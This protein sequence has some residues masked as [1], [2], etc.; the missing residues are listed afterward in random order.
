M[1]RFQSLTKRY[2]AFAAVEDLTFEVAR[3]ESVALWGPNGAGKTTAIKCLL[4]LLR[5]S[6]S[7]TVDGIE[8]RRDGRRARSRMGYVPQELAFYPEL[9]VR[10]T[11]RYYARLRRVDLSG[12]L[13]STLE[14]VGL[15]EHGHKHVSALS[16]GMKQRLALGLALL[17]SPPV[18]VLDEPTANLDA[19]ARRQFLG[20]LARVRR[21][22]Q[23]VIFT[24][25]RRE[26]V[27]A[28]AAWVLVM[29]RGRERL[30]CPATELADAVGLRS[31]LHLR[32][33][34]A[35]TGPALALLRA[36]GYD[37]RRNGS[38]V[39]LEVSPSRK[40][41]PI[42]SLTREGIGVID[43]HVEQE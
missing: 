35:D 12:G 23:T 43:L 16:G 14:I 25:H 42:A 6:G 38:G 9:S 1:I 41:E 4:G 8:A 17:G 32:L 31:R 15:A 7:I 10:D 21:E 40:V 36:A 13:T 37:A 26:E 20:I 28:L 19:A 22:G 39:V 33:A 29:Q 24:S 11:L 2:G 18:L 3:G 34:E 30:R 5:F 27:E